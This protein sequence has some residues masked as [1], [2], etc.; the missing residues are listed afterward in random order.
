MR[1]CAEARKHEKTFYR[2][3]GIKTWKLEEKKKVH[4]FDDNVKH[5]S[6]RVARWAS[7]CSKL[8]SVDLPERIT[9]SK[10]INYSNQ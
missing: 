3:S 4:M 9:C 5:K 2:N 7:K 6:H 1:K 8:S 10:N